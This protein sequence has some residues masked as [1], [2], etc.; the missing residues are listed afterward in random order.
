MILFEMIFRGCL[1]QGMSY[2]NSSSI[3]IVCVR[4]VDYFS[5]D[6]NSMCL[7]FKLFQFENEIIN[8]IS[9]K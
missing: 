6:Y 9:K 4:G 7:V 2:S 5:R 3:I 8:S 1:G